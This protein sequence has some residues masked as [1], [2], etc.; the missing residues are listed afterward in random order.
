MS[1][2]YGII[3]IQNKGTFFYSI[4][5]P[6][7]IYKYF[8]S[9]DVEEH[10]KTVITNLPPPKRHNGKLLGPYKLSRIIIKYIQKEYRKNEHNFGLEQTKYY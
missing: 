3:Q 9:C 8:N 1:P 5:D 2:C 6:M 10:G 4:G 7:N